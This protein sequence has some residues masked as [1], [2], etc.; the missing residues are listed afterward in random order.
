MQLKR[1]SVQEGIFEGLG[2]GSS[3]GLVE[4]GEELLSQLRLLEVGGRE[5]DLLE[6]AAELFNYEK[7]LKVGDGAAVSW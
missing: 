2:L 5:R 6:V 4:R 1:V 7:E 3:L